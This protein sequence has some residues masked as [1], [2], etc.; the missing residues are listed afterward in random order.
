[1][2]IRAVVTLLQKGARPPFVRACERGRMVSSPVIGATSLV[3]SHGHATAGYWPGRAKPGCD[4]S[5][6]S[7]RFRH[8]VVRDVRHAGMAVTIGR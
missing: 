4:P 7:P 6:R 3:R 1:M 5:D 8:A 2:A